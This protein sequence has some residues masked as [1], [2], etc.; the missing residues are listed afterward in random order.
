MLWGGVV[1]PIL[2]TGL[3]WA[4]LGVVNP[5]LE[6]RVDWAWF[7]VSQIAFGLAAGFVVGRAQPIATMQTWPLAARAGVAATGLERPRDRR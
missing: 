7:I 6:Q 5:T 3:V 4:V 1:A 2:W